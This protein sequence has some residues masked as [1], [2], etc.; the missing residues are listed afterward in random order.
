DQIFRI[1]VRGQKD[2]LHVGLLLARLGDQLEPGHARH[3]LI[4]EDQIDLMLAQHLERF[5]ARRDRVH[6]VLR[7]EQ[8]AEQIE[9]DL[10]VVDAQDA[11]RFGSAA[12]H[13]AR[14]IAPPW[15]W[16]T[17]WLGGMRAGLPAALLVL[18]AS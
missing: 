12:R 3:L 1:G 10:V 13:G 17:E 7:R 9:D 15:R 6:L 14:I 4:G 2:R 8:A 18:L 11:R 5:V 16:Y